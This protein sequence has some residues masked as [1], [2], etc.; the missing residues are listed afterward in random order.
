MGIFFSPTS[1][2]AAA[3]AD[4]YYVDG[5]Y[6]SDSESGS[7]SAPWKTIARAN[8]VLKAG[9]T[10]YIKAGTY[11]ET[12]R[13]VRSG[14]SGN[15][16]TYT[17]YKNDIVAIGGS[18]RNGADL[19][20]RSWIKIDGLHFIDTNRYWIEFE[21]SGSNNYI[22]NSQFEAK[23][24][25]MGYEGL[26]LRSRADYN[27]II[28]NSFT[29]TCTPQDLVQIW[30]SSYNLVE[31]NDFYY[32][33]HYALNIQ[34]RGKTEYNI[35]RNNTFDNPYH[36]ALGVWNG[37]TH[38][39]VEGNSIINSGAE[40]SLD[41]CPKNKCGGDAVNW[42]KE[43]HSGLQIAAKY[44][45]VRNNVLENNGRFTISS[46]EGDKQS[47]HNRLYN[48]TI[49]GNYIGYQTQT[50]LNNPYNDNI[51]KNNIFA[52]NIQQN[53]FFSPKITETD[54]HFVS[55]AFYG[56]ASNNYKG[57]YRVSDIELKYPREWMGNFQIENTIKDSGVPMIDPGFSNEKEGD[58][59]LQSDSGL[60]D[61]GSWLTIITTSSGSGKQFK[62]ADS[63]Y[64]SDGFGIISGDRIQIQNK[65]STLCITNVDYG[66]NT[67]FVDRSITWNKGDGV[68]LPY[69]GDSPD[70]GA[71]EH[72]LVSPILVSDDDN[73]DNLLPP[74]LSIIN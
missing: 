2:L 22:A 42:N 19:S 71:F 64:F 30:D 1:F 26:H 62:V 44:S 66:T 27:K 38:T 70:I 65:K 50:S 17:K 15:Y 52:K 31:N 36:S 3:Q 48:N 4:E 37:A 29:S 74:T 9:D 60:I 24:N 13:P 69:A 49:F 41:S 16:I 40:C 35:V 55:N 73:T 72:Q 23:Y 51:V 34:A 67:I 56:S 63:K 45:I 18:I 6:G 57:A 54:N 21:P 7:S 58:F 20:N 32:A 10:V 12:I 68:S 5:R 33:A 11:A 59:T 28:N 8:N 14:N 39:L 47:S 43:N 25:S 46:W 53:L 61:K